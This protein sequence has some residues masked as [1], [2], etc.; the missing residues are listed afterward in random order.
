MS[1]M[2]E[3]EPFSCFIV[4]VTASKTSSCSFD[5]GRSCMECEALEGQAYPRVHTLCA[6]WI[7]SAKMLSSTSESESVRRWRW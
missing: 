2:M 4:A 5:V 7:S 6:R 3:Y 1:E